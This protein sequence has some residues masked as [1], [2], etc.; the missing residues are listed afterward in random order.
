M[1]DFYIPPTS[2]RHI[3]KQKNSAM[4]GWRKITRVENSR[5]ESGRYEHEKMIY[6]FIVSITMDDLSQFLSS[7]FALMLSMVS[8]RG[9]SRVIVVS[10]WMILTKMQQDIN[11]WHVLNILILER[12]LTSKSPE[13]NS[14]YTEYENDISESLYL[15]T[16][17][18]SLSVYTRWHMFF[19]L[20]IEITKS[21]SLVW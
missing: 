17:K 10:S 3:A 7:I 5:R 1:I 11:S 15:P 20:L 2:V 21:I 19:V 6:D 8:L 16:H 9:T 14:G 12:M 4:D 18:S 13:D